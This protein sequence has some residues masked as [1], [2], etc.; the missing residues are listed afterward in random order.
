MTP[1]KLRFS[2]DY[3]VRT[4]ENILLSELGSKMTAS[5]KITVQ[6]QSRVVSKMPLSLELMFS[7]IRVESGPESEPDISLNQR[8]NPI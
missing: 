4:E 6:S 3:K 7:L 8:Y 1:E 5:M 2:M